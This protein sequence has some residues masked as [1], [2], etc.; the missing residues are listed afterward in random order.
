MCCRL[1]APR[2]GLSPRGRGKPPRLDWHIPPPS[3]Y[4]RVG[5]GNGNKP[6]IGYKRVGLSPRGRGKL[7]LLLVDRRRMRSIPA[8]AGETDA[9]RM[10]E[11]LAEVY[12]RVGG[13]NAACR[14][15]G[16][17]LTGLSPRGRG[18][19]GRR[20]RRNDGL[21][22]IPAWAGETPKDTPCRSATRVYP[23]VGGGNHTETAG[24]DAGVGLSPRGR[25][26]QGDAGR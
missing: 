6:L 1:T 23:R 9:W 16:A 11:R 15:A 10:G 24:R 12:P 2:M 19:H 20:R 13:G 17:S 22:S 8:W 26:K 14:S 7:L 4:P 3:V 18:K 21:G 25:G 5:G